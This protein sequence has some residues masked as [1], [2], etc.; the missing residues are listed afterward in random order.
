MS[1]LTDPLGPDLTATLR[2]LKLGKL[3][4]TLPESAL[5][6]RNFNFVSA[7]AAGVAARGGS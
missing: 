7:D 5:A 2:A 6:K 4:A 3:T 1:P